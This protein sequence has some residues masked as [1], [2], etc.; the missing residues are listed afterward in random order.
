MKFIHLG[1]L[2]L[3]RTLGDF[4]LLRDQKYA[5]EQVIGTV[6]DRQADAVLIAG[7]VYDKSVPSEGATALFNWLLN[8]MS[9][10]GAA[11]YI[12]SG[13]HDSD[14]RLNFGSTLFEINNIH[15]VSVFDGHLAVRTLEDEWGEVNIYMLPFVKASQVRY[16]FPDEKIA[17]YEDAVRT[18]TEDAGIDRNARNILIAHQFVTGESG[19]P[20]LGGSEGAGTLN[21]GLVERIGSSCFAGFDYTALGHIHSPQKVGNERIRYSGSLLKYSVD[22]ANNDKSFPFVTMG[23]K[24]DVQIET[25]PIKPLHDLRHIKGRLKEILK[26]ENVTDPLDFIYATLTDEETVNDAMAIIQQTYPHCVKLDFENKRTG[27]DIM[28]GINN[29]A[30]GKSFDELIRDFYKKVYDADMDEEE[31]R[32]LKAVAGKAGVIDEAD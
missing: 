11:V 22:E 29:Q 8:E 15:I 18:V 1:D 25:I 5:L 28:P 3:G 2:H 6:K 10:T 23:K 4:E 14:E 30:F 13:N 16:Y 17:N 20:A 12:I 19:A 32:I 21:V 7:D 9:D 24:G 31:M 26:P 27:N